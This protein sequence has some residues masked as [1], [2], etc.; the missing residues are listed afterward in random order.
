MTQKTASVS[1]FGWRYREIDSSTIRGDS[2]NNNRA[3]KR[4]SIP[5]HLTLNVRNVII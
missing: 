1:F 2:C 5:L 4:G 3:G